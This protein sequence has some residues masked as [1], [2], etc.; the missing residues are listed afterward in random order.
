MVSVL[1]PCDC[2]VRKQMSCAAFRQRLSWFSLIL[3]GA[4]C[5]LPPSVWGE[6]LAPE[7]ETP[8]QRGYRLLTTKPYQPADFTAGIFNDVWK[9]WPAAER[10]AAEGASPAERRRMSFSRYGLIEAPDRTEGPPLAA[11]PVGADGWAMNCLA[12]HGGKVA[13]KVLPGLGNSHYAFQ[14][15]SQEVLLARQKA[16]EKLSESAAMGVFLPLGRSDGATNAQTFSVLLCGMRDLDLNFD[17]RRPRPRFQH[18]DLDP[19]PLW[20]TKRKDRLYIDGYVKK[21]PRAIMQFVLVP[22]NTGE[23]VRGWEQDFTDVLAWIESLEPPKYP[24]AFN[25]ELAA[26]GK[27]AFER[28][29]SRCHG[30]YGPDGK[31][32]EQMVAIEEVATDD[33]RLRGMPAEHRRFMRDSWLGYYGKYEVVEDPPGYV[34]PPLDGVWASAPYFHNGSVPTL[35]HV[36]HP[37]AR[38]KIWRRTEDGYDQERVG[39]EVTQFD[40]LPAE[41]TDA[42]SKRRYF[43]TNLRGKNAAGH[44]F[45]NQLSDEEKL[46]VL[47][48]LKTL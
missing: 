1:E 20:N 26:R 27:H 36:L 44:T 46:A 8:A 28:E 12:C 4:I 47:E 10:A 15:L 48:Y 21:T 31:Y 32:R 3:T 11:A 35:W 38:P 45:P 2:C 42:I 17:P 14:T 24:W 34:A 33:A 29:C 13:G 6:D 23:T 30:T 37:E 39:L 18:Y 25:A 41:A 16:G 9:T 40:A 19:P 43:D 7:N 22:D 5:C